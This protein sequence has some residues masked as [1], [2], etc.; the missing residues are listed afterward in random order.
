MSNT[1]TKSVASWAVAARPGTLPMIGMARY[2]DTGAAPRSIWH[3]QRYEAV[4][5]GLRLRELCPLQHQPSQLESLRMA[6]VRGRSVSVDIEGTKPS[7]PATAHVNAIFV[8]GGTGP[9][10]WRRPV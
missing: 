10:P 5:H 1:L 9:Y 3:V 2:G 6:G 8:E 4:Q 7:A